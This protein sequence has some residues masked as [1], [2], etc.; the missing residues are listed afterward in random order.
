MQ[1]FRL[2]TDR[3]YHSSF[4]YI[5]CT[6][7]RFC[8]SAKKKLWL[9]PCGGHRVS[10][11]TTALEEERSGGANRIK[12]GGFAYTHHKLLQILCEAPVS[13]T[14]PTVPGDAQRGGRGQVGGGDRLL[15]LLR[16]RLLWAPFVCHWREGWEGVLRVNGM[17]GGVAIGVF[18]LD[19]F[20]FVSS[21]L[22]DSSPSLQCT[23]SPKMTFTKLATSVSLASWEVK[24]RCCW[25]GNGHRVSREP[26][27]KKAIKASIPWTLR[28]SC[29]CVAVCIVIMV[30]AFLC[31][32]FQS[33]FSFWHLVLHSFVVI[34]CSDTFV[35]FSG[36][37]VSGC[38]TLAQYKLYWIEF[39]STFQRH[40]L[41][42]YVDILYLFIVGSWILVVNNPI[43]ALMHRF[44]MYV[45]HFASIHFVG[46]F[47]ALNSVSSVNFQSFGFYF[48]SLGHFRACRKSWFMVILHI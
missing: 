18:F 7:S 31:T 32:C 26:N 17:V 14:P 43:V 42:L 24:K 13:Q 30:R 23:Q 48:A 35:A 47:A 9:D 40:D 39:F 5:I 27:Q 16:Q 25:G 2:Y 3:L 21:F 41:H 44:H 8:F 22:T 12:R 6:S 38:Q 45:H 20:F 37:F 15:V 1:T 10:A 46:D 34:S 4:F 19:F 11:L 29:C 36:Q 28:L 33:D